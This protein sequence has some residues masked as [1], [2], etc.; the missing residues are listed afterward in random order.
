MEVCFSPATGWTVAVTVWLPVGGTDFSVTLQ[1]AD[2][3]A[4]VRGTTVWPLAVVPL[5][6]TLQTTL[7]SLF[8]P[9]LVK[10][11]VKVAGGLAVIVLVELVDRVVPPT[12]TESSE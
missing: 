3:P 10:C 7:V 12:L 9:V 11:S 5:T 6:A 8:W 2:W 4:V 1:V